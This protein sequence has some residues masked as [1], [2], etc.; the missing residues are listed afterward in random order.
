M[1]KDRFKTALMIA[2]QL[3]YRDNV[4][5]IINNNTTRCNSRVRESYIIK[6]IKEAIYL[7]YVNEEYSDI[8]WK[9]GR[10]LCME[11]VIYKK[12]SDYYTPYCYNREDI[13]AIKFMNNSK[14]KYIYHKHMDKK[15]NSLKYFTLSHLLSF[16]CG[17][18]KTRHKYKDMFN[19]LLYL[20]SNYSYE[21]VT[22]RYQSQRFS[23]QLVDDM[24][25]I[26]NYITT[27]KNKIAKKANITVEHD[28]GM[29]YIFA[30]ALFY[31]EHLAFRLCHNGIE[32]KSFIS[33]IISL[34]EIFS[35]NACGR[36]IKL[37]CSEDIVNDYSEYTEIYILPEFIVPKTY[38][39]M[40]T[41]VKDIIED[42]PEG[43][44]ENAEKCIKAY[45]YNNP[46]YHFD[47]E[48]L[49]NR[50]LYINRLRNRVVKSK[51]LLYKKVK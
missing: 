14:V 11:H 41:P 48:G 9:Q 46:W 15:S 8:F 21:D 42:L 40:Y 32:D 12:P 44:K 2:V 17:L 47:D 38:E 27:T 7:V 37:I 6:Y 23:L 3:Y 30:I 10:Q 19:I 16:E 39:D 50:K 18:L 13:S 22:I 31:K 1:K 20:L 43:M 5:N 25:T 29:C 24:K 28:Y 35:H 45:E 51:N 49:H 33:M 26:F 4:L 34:H 36:G